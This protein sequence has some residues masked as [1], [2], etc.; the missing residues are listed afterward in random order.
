MEFENAMALISILQG[1]IRQ[2]ELEAQREGRGARSVNPDVRVVG[3]FTE[4]SAPVALKGRDGVIWLTTYDVD[5]RLPLVVEEDLGV[6]GEELVE[7]SV[8]EE[9]FWREG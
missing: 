2:G 3:T 5:G 8:A 9:M 4:G 1:Y 6:S 7:L